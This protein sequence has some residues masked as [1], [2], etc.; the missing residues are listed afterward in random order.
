RTFTG[1]GQSFTLD[2][3]AGQFI[4]LVGNPVSVMI[5]GKGLSGSF[6]FEQSTNAAMQRVIRIS[7]TNL[8]LSLGNDQASVLSVTNAGGF[9]VITDAGI[10]GKLSA[11]I[12]VT[13]PGVQFGGTFAVA[14]SKTGAQPIN[15]MVTDPNGVMFPVTAPANTESV[16]VTG[17]NVTLS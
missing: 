16:T 10:A 5:A 1:G 7:V 13:L 15:E 2:L 4:R 11:T 17:T 6:A 12:G 3:P 8:S 14:I 9:L